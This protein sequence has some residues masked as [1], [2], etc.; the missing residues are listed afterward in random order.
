MK[1]YYHGVGA[2]MMTISLFHMYVWTLLNVSDNLIISVITFSIG[3]LFVIMG[4]EVSKNN[5]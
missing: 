3:A 5:A 4:D 1:S 2:V